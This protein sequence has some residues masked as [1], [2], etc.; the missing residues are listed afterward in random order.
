M[1]SERTDW[2]KNWQPGPA[3]Y[4]RGRSLETD[5]MFLLRLRKRAEVCGAVYRARL[6]ECGNPERPTAA[7]LQ[8]RRDVERAWEIFG[9]NFNRASIGTITGHYRGPTRVIAFPIAGRTYIVRRGAASSR[10]I[11]R[12]V[13]V[14]VRYYAGRRIPG[15]GRTRFHH[16]GL[17]NEFGQALG[18]RCI[19]AK[20]LAQQFKISE[21]KIHLAIKR[22]HRKTPRRADI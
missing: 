16:I 19:T 3:K 20:K 7:L 2:F 17:R 22:Y 15:V 13:D 21:A 12:L 11:A 1:S 10:E 18:V 5:P 9:V 6:R 14:W 4:R 8:A